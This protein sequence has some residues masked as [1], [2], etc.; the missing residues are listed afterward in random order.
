MIIQRVNYRR[1]SDAIPEAKNPGNLATVDAETT[2]SGGDNSPLCGTIS[3]L[4]LGNNKY[5]I[6]TDFNITPLHES[7]FISHYWN[8]YESFLPTTFPPTFLPFVAHRSLSLSLS[9]QFCLFRHRHHRNS[10][11]RWSKSS[12]VKFLRP[13]VFATSNVRGQAGSVSSFRIAWNLWGLAH[14]Y[15]F[16]E[17]R[18]YI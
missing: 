14:R 4:C 16:I 17:H 1:K 5:W 13:A 18:R 3:W 11:T 12:L 8:S 10:V 15:T 6:P 2:L 7:S 9:L